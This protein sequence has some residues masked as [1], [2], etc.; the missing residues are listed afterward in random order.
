MRNKASLPVP[1]AQKTLFVPVSSST[2][3]GDPKLHPHGHLPYQHSASLL[4]QLHLSF[5][6]E[7]TQKAKL[8]LWAVHQ[9]CGVGNCFLKRTEKL[10]EE[11]FLSARATVL[12][13]FLLFSR[14][15]LP[16]FLSF[17]RGSRCCQ[18]YCSLSRTYCT[19]SL[20]PMIFDSTTNVQGGENE[21]Q[22]QSHAHFP[23]SGGLAAR[24]HDKR[25]RQGG[26]LHSNVPRRHPDRSLWQ[27]MHRS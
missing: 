13:S 25:L 15:C 8:Y 18:T 12:V 19:V 2:V 3:I 20:Q 5:F 27:P 16:K 24:H 17:C 21:S 7:S 6:T 14:S 1:T 9:H 23:G 26:Q 11:T 4:S 10:R 22:A